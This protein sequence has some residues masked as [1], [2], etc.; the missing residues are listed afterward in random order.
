MLAEKGHHVSVFVND[1]SIKDIKVDVDDHSV[2]VVR[3]NTSQTNSSEALG[4][5]TNICYEFAHVLKKFIE[6]EGKPDVIESQEYLGIA[7][8]FLQY[9]YLGYEWCK[10]IP[11][12][13]TMHSPTFLYMEYNH[14]P[15]YSYP[16]FWVCEMERFCLQA[17]DLLIS[18]SQFMLTELKKR[19][20]LKNS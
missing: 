2:R 1:L 14:I 9:R 16:N 8:Y 19:F 20:E 11:V 13:I 6:K 17:A 10:D 7:Y 18:P 12:I 4:H 15:L 3:F 5:V